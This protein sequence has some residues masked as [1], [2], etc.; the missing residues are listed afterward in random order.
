MKSIFYRLY[1]RILKI[2]KDNE[3]FV[4]YASSGVV[5]VT[6]PWLAIY[7]LVDRLNTTDLLILTSVYATVQLGAF[8]DFGLSKFFQLKAR[9]SNI[10]SFFY[11]VLPRISV[12][13]IIVS[14][15]LS[16]SFIQ[17]V[18]FEDIN[19]IWFINIA[20]I[21]F[22]A[23]LR[24]LVCLKLELMGL[25]FNSTMLKLLFWM[26]FFMPVYLLPQCDMHEVFLISSILR[27]LVIIIV[28]NGITYS[29][30]KAEVLN[31]Q[32]SKSNRVDLRSILIFGLA[33]LIGNSLD[34]Y[35]P[36]LISDSQ[37]KIS[38]ILMMDI[39]IKTTF[40]AGAFG[41]AKINEM[42]QKGI[43]EGIGKKFISYISLASGISFVI[44]SLITINVT[45]GSQP[46]KIIFLFLFLYICMFSAN[47]ILVPIG[48]RLVSVRII[49]NRSLIGVI[50][51]IIMISIGI[52]I[53]S[54]L[55]A[56]CGLIVKA[57]YE[58]VVYSRTNN[59]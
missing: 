20:G 36:G 30:R 26:L 43:D 59:A 48:Q 10:T 37:T 2:V 47:Q 4:K 12:I 14:L 17:L 51:A 19:F 54:I 41:Q 8:S 18:K 25:Y 35:W 29:N 16:V 7:F 27:V 38:F 56:I 44:I 11:W 46:D 55:F 13:S 58:F 6:I 9:S 24:N 21:I 1:S 34:R 53:E 57:S 28:I 42:F 23:A 45:S 50:L 40:F 15:F 32:L 52:Y 3:N 39:G 49:A 31:Y 33:C 5:N 22:S